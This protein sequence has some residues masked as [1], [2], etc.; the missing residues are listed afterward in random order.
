MIRKQMFWTGVAFITPVLALQILFLFVPVT[1]SLVYSFTNWRGIGTYQF[2][3]LDNYRSIFSDASYINSLRRTIVIGFSTAIAANLLGLMLAILLDQS[4]KT[5]KLLRLLVYVPNIIPV[6]VS[7]FIWRYLLD[8]NT[9][10]VNLG[11]SKLLGLPVVIPWI[12]TPSYV[13]PSVVTIAVWQLMGP[14]IIIYIAALQGVSVDLLEASAIDGAGAIR[15][16]LSITLPAIAPGITVNV[17]I[18]LANGIR[19]FDLPWAL[20]GGGPAGASET[21]GIKIYRYAFQSANLGYAMASAF[22]LT[23]LAICVT[24]VFVRLVRRYELGVT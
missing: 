18:G 23:C 9:G 15:K 2:I 7:A 13:V 16:F 14:I 8:A 24:V 22:T 5:G 10:L 1:V 17:L 21:L 12:D 6:V 19:I 4:I 11:L 3:G 20:T